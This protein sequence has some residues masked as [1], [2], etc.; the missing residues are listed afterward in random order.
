MV[1]MADFGLE[2]AF[3]RFFGALFAFGFCFGIYLVIP[4]TSILFQFCSI[5]SQRATG[6]IRIVDSGNLA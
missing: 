4:S 2:L 6:R 5:E 3:V 1:G